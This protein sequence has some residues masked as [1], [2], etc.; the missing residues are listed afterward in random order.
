MALA[1]QGSFDSRAGRISST[2]LAK[3]SGRMERKNPFDRIARQG[4]ETPPN[5]SAEKPPLPCL[6]TI[7]PRSGGCTFKSNENSLGRQS[8][9]ETGNS[10]RPGCLRP[11]GRRWI[12]GWR[13]F[14]APCGINRVHP[15]ISPNPFI[16][17]HAGFESNRSRRP[18]SANLA[19][20]S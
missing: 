20:R 16:S 12:S 4:G 14:H 19:L 9:R 2:R 8:H 3:R 1:A 5:L 18:I 13:H 11:Y 15:A 7:H 17:I 6:Q 10:S